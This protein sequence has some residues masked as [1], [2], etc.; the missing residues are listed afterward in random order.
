MGKHVLTVVVAVIIGVSLLLYMFAYQVRTS[1]VAVVLTFG[2][3]SLESPAPGYHFKWPWP[4]QEVRRFDNRIHVE[5]GRFEEMYT[6]DRYNIIISLAAG[7]KISDV[8]TFNRNFGPYDEPVEQAWLAIERIMRDRTLKAIGRHDL[9]ELVSADPDQIKFN[10]IEA[11][12]LESTQDE[13]AEYYGADFALVKIRR[14]ELP[15]SATQKVYERM[16]SE[17]GAEA[18]RIQSD[19]Q[20]TADVIR[21]EA[22]SQR[23]QIIA[24]ANSEAIRIRG[25][26][27]AE[28][29]RY[30]TV[31]AENP[32]LAIYLRKIKALREATRDNTTVILDTTTPPFDLLVSEPPAPRLVVPPEKI[33]ADSKATP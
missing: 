10:D 26:G 5:E 3:P 31:F 33:G 24:L 4:I 22:D 14:L 12:I 21:G 25:E 28:A 9:R 17:R 19:A 6:R 13:A 23:E 32:E 20:Q 7:W 11:E 30:F 8:Q 2:K 29:A 27:D 15:E 18:Q 16:K 1:E